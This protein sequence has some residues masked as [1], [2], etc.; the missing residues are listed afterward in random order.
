LPRA[1]ESAVGGPTGAGCGERSAARLAQRN[2]WRERD[3]QSR[4]GTLELGIA[5]LRKGGYF[6]GFLGA[7]APAG[8]ADVPPGD[9]AAGPMAEK[10]RTAVIHR[11]PAGG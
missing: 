5:R 10:A 9:R 3:G 4:A 11:P 2:G 6:P 8:F 1:R 7:A